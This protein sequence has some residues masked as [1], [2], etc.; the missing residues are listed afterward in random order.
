MNIKEAY[1]VMQKASG[2]KKGD[3]IK[4]LRTSIEDEMG[5]CGC[6][7]S[8]VGEIEKVTRTQGED[9]I[10]ID[11]YFWYPFFILEVVEKAKDENMIT[12]A[13]KEYSEATLAKAMKE[14]V[15]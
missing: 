15:K 2:I 9:G 5:Y 14:Y 1:E 12:V 13:G 4:I 8:E 7:T 10:Q 6:S 11:G 3:K